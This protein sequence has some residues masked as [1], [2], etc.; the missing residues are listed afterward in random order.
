M[1]KIGLYVSLFL[2]A[3]CSVGQNAKQEKKLLSAV[4]FKEFLAEDSIQLVDVRTPEEFST[5]HIDGALNLD[6]NGSEFSKQ[7]STL[8]K[9]QTVMLYCLGGGRSAKAADWFIENGFI[10]VLEL[11]GGMM[12][13]R[14]NGFPEIQVSTIDN[15]M[16][17]I[18]FDQLIR[19]KALVLVDFY[20]EWCAPCQKMKPDLEK[21]NQS[22]NERLKVVRLDVD[23][24]KALTTELGI[25]ALPVLHLYKSGELVWSHKGYIDKS[26]MD[27]AIRKHL[28]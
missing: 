25:S 11:E 18:D 6:W 16:S 17:R 14:S 20:A 3:S 8:D 4:E 9:N 13:W 19:T 7:A 22:N 26:G 12:N 28:E 21:I 5:G 15:G 27:D 23:Q 2:I 1:S 10:R 24:H